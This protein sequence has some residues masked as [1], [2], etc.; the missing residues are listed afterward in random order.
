MLDDAGS[1]CTAAAV[2]EC[3]SVRVRVSNYVFNYFTPIT[4]VVNGGSTTN[5]ITR[6]A[7]FRFER[8]GAVN[9]TSPP[10]P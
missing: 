10:P 2:N 4:R 1:A 6:E 3:E 7:I 8:N 9:P 5:T